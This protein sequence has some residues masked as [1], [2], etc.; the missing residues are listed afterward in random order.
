[1][2]TFDSNVVLYLH[3]DSEPDKQAVAAR[4]ISILAAQR[5]P[6]ALQVIGETQNILR[7][8]FNLPAPLVAELATRILMG[9]DMATPTPDDAVLALGEMAQGRLN[10]WDALLVACVKRNGCTALM[11]EDMQDGAMLL[12]VEIVNPFGQDG[13]SPRAAALLAA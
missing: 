8:K 3:D 7:R 9:F 13:L 2:I 11:T 5:S 12:G 4:V 6:V 1:M 10:Y